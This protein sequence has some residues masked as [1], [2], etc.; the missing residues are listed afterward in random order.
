LKIFLEIGLDQLEFIFFT[1]GIGQPDFY[2]IK[3]F[4]D[5]DSKAIDEMH[6]P[7]TGADKSKHTIFPQLIAFALFNLN[8]KTTTSNIFLIFPLRLYPLLEHVQIAILIMRESY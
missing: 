2:L 1:G 5:L 4:P 3:L 7:I 8:L 6:Q